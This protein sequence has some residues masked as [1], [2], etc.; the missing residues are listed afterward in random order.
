[1]LVRITRHKGY[2][3]VLHLRARGTHL[4]SPVPTLL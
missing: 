4:Q 1:V 3:V 2:V